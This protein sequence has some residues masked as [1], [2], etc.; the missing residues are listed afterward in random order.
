[1][2]CLTLQRGFQLLGFLDHGHDLLV[3]AGA[4]GLLDTDGQLAFFYHGSGIDG[5]TGDFS[6]R[7]G[8]SGE[9]CLVHHAFSVRHCTIEGDHIAHVDPYQIS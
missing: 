9:R 8:F 7:N 6:H 5:S 1:M 4:A 2:L 3:F